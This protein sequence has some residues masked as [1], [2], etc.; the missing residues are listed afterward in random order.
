[1]YVC[2]E[3]GEKESEDVYLALISPSGEL[4]VRSVLSVTDGGTVGIAEFG[5]TFRNVPF[6][7][8]GLY[9][10]RLFVGGRVLM[11]RDILLQTPPPPASAQAD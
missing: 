7:A 5:V 1:V 4:V 2:L 6:V 8:P 3:R 11:E 9:V 10:L